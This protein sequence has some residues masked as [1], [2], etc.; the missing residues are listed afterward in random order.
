MS[1]AIWE[2]GRERQVDAK[3]ATRVK[4]RTALWGGVASV[5]GGDNH[6]P[7]IVISRWAW[8]ESFEG[9]DALAAAEAWLD[10]VGAPG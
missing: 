8:T 9:E 6:K 3:A 10:Q 5:L 2:A 7:L 1:F 4:A